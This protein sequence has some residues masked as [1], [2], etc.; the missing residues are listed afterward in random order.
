M[1]HSCECKRK[2]EELCQ[3]GNDPKHQIGS[4]IIIF[5]CLYNCLALIQNDCTSRITFSIAFEVSSLFMSLPESSM[6]MSILT[7]RK[8]ASSNFHMRFSSTK[9]TSNFTN[10]HRSEQ[11]VKSTVEKAGL[12][13][14][15]HL[16][17]KRAPINYS[18]PSYPIWQEDRYSYIVTSQ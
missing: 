17:C 18:Y 3:I 6:V 15:Y 1:Q 16:H 11:I 9:P 4:S 14:L 12:L 5:E 8:S 7:S 2:L 10:I 13:R